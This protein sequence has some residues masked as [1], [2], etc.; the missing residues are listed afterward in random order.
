MGADGAGYN[1]APYCR[2]YEDTGK[3]A[4]ILTQECFQPER[5]EISQVERQTMSVDE[6]AVVLG[7]SRPT[8]YQLAHSADFPAVRIGR[9]IRIPITGL[10]RWIKGQY[11]VQTANGSYVPNYGKEETA[12]KCRSD[13]E[14]ERERQRRESLKEAIMKQIDDSDCQDSHKERLRRAIA[15]I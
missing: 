10:E 2:C 15:Y 7:V 1:P 3:P 9:R 8:A 4:N 14:E 11:D 12:E 6:M 5:K 13:P